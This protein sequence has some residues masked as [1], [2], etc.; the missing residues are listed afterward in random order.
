MNLGEKNILKIKGSKDK[1]LESRASLFNGN[2]FFI[3]KTFMRHQKL[4]PYLEF[5]FPF[6]QIQCC[7][8]EFIQKD[9]LFPTFQGYITTSLIGHN[10]FLTPPLFE[11]TKNFCSRYFI[12]FSKKMSFKISQVRFL[13]NHQTTHPP[14]TNSTVFF[15]LHN[16]SA[17]LKPKFQNEAHFFYIGKIIEQ[18]HR[19]LGA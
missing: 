16:N 11:K 5:M 3:V 7:F 12:I 18:N 9:P 2:G 1:N 15:Y 4:I 6:F 13:K 10:V 8:S 19:A 17:I 14:T